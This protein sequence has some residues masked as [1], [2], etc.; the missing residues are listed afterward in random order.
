M[1]TPHFK[2]LNL[3]VLASNTAKIENLYSGSCDLQ[4]KNIL[5]RKKWRLLDKYLQFI[6]K[7]IHF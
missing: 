5:S 4:M 1:T 7:S 2:L 3:R 6:D